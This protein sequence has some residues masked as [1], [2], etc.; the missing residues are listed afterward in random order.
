[1]RSVTM[2]QENPNRLVEI[3]PSQ[4]EKLIEEVVRGEAN[5]EVEKALVPIRKDINSFCW[6]S[7][8]TIVAFTI[9]SLL[10]DDSR[11]IGPV[12]M[13]ALFL[14]FVVPLRHKARPRTVVVYAKWVFTPEEKHDERRGCGIERERDGG[15]VG[16][17][18]DDGT[19]AGQEHGGYAGQPDEGA[20]GAERGGQE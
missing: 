16:Q 8:A 6:T 9:L 5:R 11:Y 17:A 12:A 13:I 19:R 20:G 3:E 2:S 7:T 14:V 18:R 4:L 10:N 1:M 15:S